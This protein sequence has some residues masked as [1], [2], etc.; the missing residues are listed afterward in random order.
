M[1]VVRRLAA[2]SCALLAACASGSENNGAEVDARAID[3][4]PQETDA[5]VVDA[6]VVDTPDVDAPGIDAPGIDAPAIDAASIDAAN[7]DAATTDAMV[8]D[9][10]TDAAVDAGI[11]AGCTTMVLQLL[12]NQNFDATPVGTGWVETPH[13]AA[14]PIITTDGFT[15]HTGTYKAFLGGYRVVS[16]SRVYQQLTVPASTTQ[17][18]LRGQFHV[19]TNE[20]GGT[21]YDTGNVEL[22][23]SS[24][25]LLQSVMAL[26]N[27]TTNAGWAPFNY[28][29]PTPYAGQVV[30]LNF[31]SATDSTLATWFFFDTLALEA[32]VCQ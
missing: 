6:P 29:F 9:A 22:L 21:A 1:R 8:T 26:S 18:T 24:G 5:T 17:L 23:N 14:E 25:G 19:E 20:S 11:D 2:A 4:P 31:R 30:R 15:A 27:V 12:V 28:T 7:I 16:A 10:A 32:T 13:N 3:A